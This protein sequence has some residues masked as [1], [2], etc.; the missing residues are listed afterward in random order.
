LRELHVGHLYI[1]DVAYMYVFD[2]FG[3]PVYVW[4]IGGPSL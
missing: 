3:L 2:S 1:K 4:V